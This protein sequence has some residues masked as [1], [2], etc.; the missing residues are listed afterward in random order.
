MFVMRVKEGLLG[1]RDILVTCER[2]GAHC[3]FR[4]TLALDTFGGSKALAR[5]TSQHAETHGPLPMEW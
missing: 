2:C 5:W 3:E 1:T 4:I